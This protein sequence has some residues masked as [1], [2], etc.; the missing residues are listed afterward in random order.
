MATAMTSVSSPPKPT[1]PR[2]YLAVIRTIDKFTEWTGHIFVLFI[3]PLVFA[4]VFEVF[5]HEGD[6]GGFDGD[7]GSGPDRDPH[8]GPGQSGRVVDSVSH[9]GDG[10]SA[11]LELGDLGRLVGR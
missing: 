1:P 11:F 10:L 6:V 2:G 3:I 9:H 7:V 4:N 5:A 8:V